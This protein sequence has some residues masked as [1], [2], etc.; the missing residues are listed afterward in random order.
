MPESHEWER[1]YSSTPSLTLTLDGVGDHRHAPAALA[2]GK[3]PG[4]HCIGGWVGSGAGLDDLAPIR[5][6]PPDRPARSELLNRL[7]N[8]GSQQQ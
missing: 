8:P 3:R 4:T 5:I 2:S 1:M 7:N 6:R